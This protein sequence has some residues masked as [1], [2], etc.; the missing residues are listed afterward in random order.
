VGNPQGAQFEVPVGETLGVPE[1][2]TMGTPFPPNEFVQN[3]P[4]PQTAPQVVPKPIHHDPSDYETDLP[5]DQQIHDPL[6]TTRPRR[7]NVGT[8]NDGPAKI[9]ACPMEN[10]S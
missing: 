6:P 3:H 4:A 10:E 5:T 1:G 8:W 2:V 9:R 7:H